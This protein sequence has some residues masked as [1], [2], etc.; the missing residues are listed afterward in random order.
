MYM[1]DWGEWQDDLWIQNVK[2][3]CYHYKKLYFCPVIKQKKINQIDPECCAF[4]GGY[5]RPKKIYDTRIFH[6]SL[7]PYL[8]IFIYI[9][10]YICNIISFSVQAQVT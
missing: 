2:N 4:F 7:Q 1:W 6:I 9:F 3:E 10:Y 8:G 5:L